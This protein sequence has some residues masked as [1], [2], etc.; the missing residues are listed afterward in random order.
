MVELVANVYAQLTNTVL[1]EKAKER[2]KRKGETDLI[3]VLFLPLS[4]LVLCLPLSLSLS[5][6]L[7][8]SLSIVRVFFTLKSNINIERNERKKERKKIGGKANDLSHTFISMPIYH[9]YDHF[10]H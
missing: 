7:Y 2:E 5:L 9:R 1:K 10:L 6:S 4:L 8:P 3:I